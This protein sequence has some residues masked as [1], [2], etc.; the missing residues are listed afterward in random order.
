MRNNAIRG[1]AAAGAAAALLGIG[2]SAGPAEAV[3]A[4]ENGYPLIDNVYACEE[5]FIRDVVFQTA[6]GEPTQ[7]LKQFAEWFDTAIEPVTLGYDD[8][9]SWRPGELIPPS[10]VVYSNHGSGTSIDL[11]AE[12]HPLGQRGTFTP[13]QTAAIRAK[14]AEYGGRLAWGGDYSDIPD[15]MHF[16]IR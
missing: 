11:N 1:L 3:P 4:S 6:P 13:D 2:L 14:V 9:Y 8:D 5:W 12:R 7:L 10:G 16:E 15:E